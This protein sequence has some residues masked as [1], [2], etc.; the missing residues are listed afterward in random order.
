M[1][2]YLTSDLH[3]GHLKVS[4]IRGF[5]SVEAHDFTIVKN[6]NTI[7][8]D[9][10]VVYVLGDVMMGDRDRGRDLLRN[11]RG[12][13]HLVLG[14]HDR[15]APN[16]TNG[17][18]HQ[19]EMG[20]SWGSISTM[21][22]IGFNSRG[23]LMSHYPYEGDHAREERFNAFRLKDTGIPLFHGHTHYSSKYS[24]SSKG[25]PQYHVG[26]DAWDLSPV[27]ISNVLKDSKK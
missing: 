12:T 21:I 5:D 27:S 6:W 3:L 17:H 24:V 23:Y 25:T 8:R 9:E 22:R 2:I 14:N 16:N 4:Q 13:K 10:D 26:L 1:G 18:L 11:L 15:A 7:V 20:D 19:S